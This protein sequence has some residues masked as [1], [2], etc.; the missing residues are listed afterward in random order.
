MRFRDTIPD[1][2]HRIHFIPLVTIAYMSIDIAA[3][4]ATVSAVRALESRFFSAGIQQMPAQTA[5]LLEDTATLRAR[6]LLLKAK[7]LQ[8]RHEIHLVT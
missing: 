5:F 2:V 7:R 1:D 8:L 6:V 3:Q 4:I